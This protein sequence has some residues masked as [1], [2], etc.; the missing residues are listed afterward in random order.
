ML[1]GKSQGEVIE[2]FEKQ[3]V[4][5]GKM[6]PNSLRIL[7]D[8]VSAR[9]EF[10]KGKSTSHKIEEAR[11]NASILMNELI[12]YNQRCEIANSKDSEKKK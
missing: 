9:A 11:K 10:K 6:A 12:E 4:K 7:K 5:K 8:L 2:E 1:G 3:L